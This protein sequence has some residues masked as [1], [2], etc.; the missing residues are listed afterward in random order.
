MPNSD[1]VRHSSLRTCVSV[2]LDTY[3]K[4]FLAQACQSM[5]ENGDATAQYG[6]ARST[7]LKNIVAANNLAWNYFNAGDHRAEEVARHAYA[8]HPEHR[9]DV[10]TL[11][12]ILVKKG[13]LRDGIAMLRSAIEM[14]DD[15][16]EVRNHLAEAL[17]AAGDAEE[18]KSVLQ[19]ML[20][21][22]IEFVSRKEAADLL[23]A[24]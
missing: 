14:D 17:V 6:Q 9:A 15:K 5:Q 7:D 20:T 24:L 4:P 13:A 16:P 11:G 22:E 12:W 3:I 19:E 21:T 1:L 23:L 8:N 18:V 2:S 10:D